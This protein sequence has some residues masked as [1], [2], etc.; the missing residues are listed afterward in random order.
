[1][2]PLFYLIIATLLLPVITHAQ[3]PTPLSL[4]DALNYA[5]KHNAD[6]KNARLDVQ[7]QKAKNAQITSAAYPHVGTKLDVTSFRNPLETYLPS[8]FLTNGLPDSVVK[9]MALPEFV[10]ASFAPSTSSTLSLTANQL[11]FDGSVLVALQAKKSVMRLFEQTAM[12][13]EEGVRL[14]VQ[15]AYYGLVIAQKQ[16]NTLKGSLTLTRKMVRDQEIMKENGFVEKID[17]DRSYVQLN[18]F[19]TDSIKIANLLEVSEQMLKFQMGMDISTPIVLTDT[20]LTQQLNETISLLG[21]NLSYNN[22]TEYSLLQTQMKLMNYDLKRYRFAVLPT[23]A[24][25][26]NTG[27]NYGTDTLG[28]IISKSREYSRS[29]LFGLSINLSLFSGGLQAA[30]IKESKL[31][32]QKTQNSIGR[33]EQA[34]D[35]QTETAKTTLRNSSL[36]L[37]NQLRNKELAES[38]LDLAQKKYKAGVGSNLEVTVAQTELLKAQS[39]YYQS[40]LD[41]MNAQTDLQKALGQLK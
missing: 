14:N 41:V 7:I 33:L 5:V 25:F 2:R 21:D 34:I 4:E 3:E 40:L 24:A 19:Q 31:N 27:Y 32:I 15:K 26:Y 35:F 38:V 17:M 8:S 22:R 1:M 30:H 12:V 13:T 23:I 9:K 16:F 36:T 20:S 6:V 10:P 11:L 37:N 39:N 18:N 29:T 28:D